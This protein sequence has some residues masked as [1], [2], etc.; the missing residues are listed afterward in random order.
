MRV[1]RGIKGAF[2]SASRKSVHAPANSI[3]FMVLA[4]SRVSTEGLVN[5]SSTGCSLCR[6]PAFDSISILKACD[7]ISF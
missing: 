1:A 4:L 7:G 2:L 3:A 6:S 5:C